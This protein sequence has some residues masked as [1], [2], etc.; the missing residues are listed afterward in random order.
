MPS[1]VFYSWQKDTPDEIGFSFV[2]EALNAALKEL[3]VDITLDKAVRD[4]HL[5]RDTQNIPGQPPIADTIF[6]KIDGA[7]VFVPDL[8]FVGK[9]LDE[10]RPTSNPNVLIEY[11][12]A[13]EALGHERIVPVMNTCHGLPSDETMPFDMK[14]LRHPIQYCCEPT[15]ST[16]KRQ[17]VLKKLTQELKDQI[18]AVLKAAPSPPS[19]VLFE[20]RLTPDRFRP[21][22]LPTCV[23]YDPLPFLTS[24]NSSP[25]IF[26]DNPAAWFKIAP[27]FDLGRSWN[28][29]EII[30][31][32]KKQTS[33]LNEPL[34]FNPAGYVRAQDGFGIYLINR[35]NPNTTH[36]LVFISK[37]GELL[38]IAS[39]AF[40]YAD[41]NGQK[42]I[43]D[44]TPIFAKCLKNYSEFLIKLG[45]LPPFRWQATIQD[46][47]NLPIITRGM[48]GTPTLSPNCLEAVISAGGDYNPGDDPSAALRPFTEKLFD[49]C[50]LQPP[51]L[52]AANAP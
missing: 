11:G 32:V 18:A 10:K 44:M 29:T 15:L 52:Q 41:W 30:E 16:N 50:G 6:H 12:Y 8:T 14:H 51:P 23:T 25:V 5:D 34:S 27:T 13:V 31:L 39:N 28:V 43:R 2:E 37:Y 33:S 4:L 42:I 7:V 35:S 48:F 3:R 46:T 24:N 26:A 17:N 9:R 36:G 45:T 22:N 47:Q 19:A 49:S 38:L 40:A 21:G 20:Q 1:A